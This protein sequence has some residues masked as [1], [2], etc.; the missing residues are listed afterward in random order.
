MIAVSGAK[1]SCHLELKL[2]HLPK[3]N[4]QTQ[5]EVANEQEVFEGH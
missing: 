3:K 1:Q 2:G 4:T 5:K